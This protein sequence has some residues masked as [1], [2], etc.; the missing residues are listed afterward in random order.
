MLRTPAVGLLVAIVV[1]ALLARHVGLRLALRIGLLL[2]RLVLLLMF[3]RSITAVARPHSGLVGT[4]V[5]VAVLVGGFATALLLLVALVV[6]ILLP[7]LLLHGSDQAEIM[8]G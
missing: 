7:E 4:L 3:A 5:V 2:L 8:F 6:G 1:E